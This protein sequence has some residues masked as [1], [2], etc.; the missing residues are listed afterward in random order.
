MLHLNNA[1]HVGGFSR[2]FVTGSSP[3]NGCDHSAG[4]AGHTT[5]NGAEPVEHPHL[6]TG[7]SLSGGVQC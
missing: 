4:V 6:A 1:G 5:N 7:N 3:P 2:F